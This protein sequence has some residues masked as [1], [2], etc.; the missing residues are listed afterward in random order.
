MYPEPHAQAGCAHLLWKRE[1]NG[2]PSIRSDCN[3]GHSPLSGPPLSKQN[4]H[5]LTCHSFLPVSALI[6]CPSSLQFLTEPYENPGPR[7]KNSAG[8]GDG[9]GL[10][11]RRRP[12]E[13]NAPPF[14]SSFAHYEGVGRPRRNVLKG[15]DIVTAHL[16][17]TTQCVLLGIYPA[18]SG[19]TPSRIPYPGRCPRYTSHLQRLAFQ[20]PV[21]SA[22][23]SRGQRRARKAYEL[24]I[25][26]RNGYPFTFSTPFLHALRSGRPGATG[27]GH[28]SGKYNQGV[29]LG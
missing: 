10:G 16:V 8:W 6:V 27:T 26:S 18:L 12:A 23:P 14:G 9:A 28:A 25:Q 24:R 4:A 29:A 3:R 20:G 13:G 21:S 1:P 2:I 7:V 11:G 19:L 17:R 15:R 22:A 5:N